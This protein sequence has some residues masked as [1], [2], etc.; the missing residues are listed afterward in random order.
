MRHPSHRPTPSL[1]GNWKDA[2]RIPDTDLQTAGPAVETWQAVWVRRQ[3]WH[4]GILTA[5]RPYGPGQW[6]ARVQWGP[7][8]EQTAWLEYKA[9]AIRPMPA[10]DGGES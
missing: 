2:T 3:G 9:V 7:D 1:P 4:P 5:W 8:P 6:A 10:P